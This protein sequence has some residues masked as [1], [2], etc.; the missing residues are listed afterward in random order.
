MKILVTTPACH[1]KSTGA[2]QRDIYAALNM[3]RTMGHDVTLYTVG[4]PMQDEQFLREKVGDT[5]DV[6]VFYPTF[7]PLHW[8]ASCLRHFS[9]FDRSAHVFYLMV[10]SAAFRS[11]VDMY[12]PDRIVSFCSYSW[13]IFAFA[14]KRGI[15]SVFRSHNFEPS[16]FWETLGIKSKWSPINWLRYLAKRFAEGKA[17]RYS[18]TVAT[19][20]FAEWQWYQKR[21]KKHIFI[22]TLLFLSESIRPP[23]VQT[24]EEPIDIFYLGASYNVIFHLRGVELLIEQIAPAVLRQA[25]GTFRFHILGAKLPERLA[26]QCTG[27][28]IYHGYVDD[29]DGFLDT[30]DA[31]VFPVMTGKTMKGKV[32]DSLVRSF[33]IVMSSNC[34][35]G[36]D[37]SDGKEVLLADTIDGF[38]EKILALRDP[39]LRQSLADNAYAYTQ[40]HFSEKQLLSI[41]ERTLHVS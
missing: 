18:T 5:V 17:L 8:L 15:P 37:L 9:L 31:A 16:F 2:A 4:S 41:F 14:K 24:K 28:I 38:V 13:P 33:P 25:P 22:L 26:R 27:N 21:K 32:F 34:L 19:L 40:K 10:K 30:M 20:P 1:F 11:F 39:S 23:K 35:G 6:R 36:Y 12:G 29:L 3:L 7:H